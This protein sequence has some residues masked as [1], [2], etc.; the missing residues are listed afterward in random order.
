MTIRRRRLPGT[1]LDLSVIS[2]GTV[3]VGGIVSEDD[4]FR[5]MDAYAV[6]RRIL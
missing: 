6:A 1:D 5:L 2:L 3:S 4:S